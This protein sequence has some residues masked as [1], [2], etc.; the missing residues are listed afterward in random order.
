MVVG[1][2]KSCILLVSDKKVGTEVV[3]EYFAKNISQLPVFV[4][5]QVPKAIVGLLKPPQ[6]YTFPIAS[7]ITDA[8]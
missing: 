5:T 4:S 8:A 6:I 3:S 2:G 7:V 1:L